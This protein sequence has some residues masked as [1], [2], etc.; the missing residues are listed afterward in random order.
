M[1]PVYVLLTFFSHVSIGFSA[2]FSPKTWGA[3]WDYSP[4]ILYVSYYGVM[5]YCDDCS[6]TGWESR[7]V[8]RG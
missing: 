6:R 2:E 3:K 8:Y 7:A 5:G 1:E 4:T